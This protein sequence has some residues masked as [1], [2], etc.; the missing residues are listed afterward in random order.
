MANQTDTK[1]DQVVMSP[2][3]TLDLVEGV[4]AGVLVIDRE[5]RFLFVNRWFCEWIGKPADSLIGVQ[6]D[7]LLTP[8][9]RSQTSSELG[10]LFEQG[11]PVNWQ[12][13]LVTQDAAIVIGEFDAQPVFCDGVIVAAQVTYKD[14]T[15]YRELIAECEAYRES[16]EC[17]SDEIDVLH[18]IGTA[19]SLTADV[20]QV[21]ELVYNQVRRLFSFSAFAL[22]LYEPESLQLLPQLVFHNGEL[23]SVEPWAYDQEQGLVGWTIRNARPLLIRDCAAERDRWPMETDR[24]FQADTGSWVSLPLIVQGQILGVLCLQCQQVLAFDDADLPSLRALADQSAVVIENVRLHQQTK[25]QL[26]E[27]QQANREMQALQDLSSLLQ[28]SLDLR[29]VYQVIVN[30]LVAGLGYEMAMLAVV[31]EKS[32]VLVIRAAGTSLDENSPE[33]IYLTTALQGVPISLESESTSIV[34]A[35]SQGRI[36]TTH[37][38][39]DLFDA[40]GRSDALQLFERALHIETV[41]IVPLLARGKLVGSLFAGGHHSEIV[42]RGISLLSAFANQSAIAI[43]NAQLYS[44]VNQ[45]LTEV[46][47]LY[48]LANEVSYSLDLDV[49]LDAIVTTLRRVLNCR[50]SVIFLYNEETKYL[51]IRA[52]DGIKPRWQRDARMHLG[53]GIT[54]IVAQE[55]RPLYIPDTYN[56]EHFIVF[57]PSVRSL[58]VVPLMV[59][60]K[61]IGT[62]S[63]DDNKVDA[64]STDEGRLLSIAA[65][66]VA[67]AIDNARL[68]EDIKERAEKLEQAYQELQEASR[69]KSEFVQN[70]SHELRTPLTFIKAYVDLLLAGTLGPLNEMQREKFQIVSDRTSSI[71]HLI[72]DIFSLQRLEREKLNLVPLSLSQVARVS[73]QGADEAARRGGLRLVEDFEDELCPALGDRLRLNQVFD[74]LIHNAIK[75]SPEGGEIRVRLCNDGDFI[76]AEVIDPGIG[77]PDDKLDKIWERFYQVDGT[78]KRRFG[79]TGLGLAIVKEIIEAHGGTVDVQS[80]FGEGSTFSFT[81]PVADIEVSHE[82]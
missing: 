76:R 79:G 52:S 28:S 16:L 38:L 56:D 34:R 62:L 48:T 81:V 70:V 14:M 35:V 33:H 77:V 20:D 53:E 27:L 23:M 45:R 36:T 13:R 44:T 42:G 31:D 74:N 49:V 30:G 10:L 46:S 57:D 72:G 11:T 55:A 51:E 37:S 41:A 4:Q 58:F 15:R 32:N 7:S 43:E 18:C 47:T 21:I 71:I 9:S 24:I 12:T 75:F 82:P 22:V 66:Q 40:L 39:G 61:V 78:S 73:I 54:G 64:F 65:A 19:G 26:Q 2:I 59:K 50:S 68:Y 67:V 80:V 8:D 5:R 17:Q 29:N 6:L 25:Y 1:V 63:V 69:L 60:G 3:P